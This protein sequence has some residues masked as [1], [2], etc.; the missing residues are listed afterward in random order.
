MDKDLPFKGW[1]TL[2]ETATKTG[3]E[4]HT[5]LAKFKRD[6]E[7]ITDKYYC[8]NTKWGWMISPSCVEKLIE[9]QQ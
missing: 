2:A 4:Y 6:K 7:K 9:E 1:F 5:L 8:L 3:I